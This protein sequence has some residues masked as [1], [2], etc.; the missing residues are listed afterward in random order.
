MAI[1]PINGIL[2]KDELKVME[3]LK[4]STVFDAMEATRKSFEGRLILITTTKNLYHARIEADT[5]L[6]NFKH[7]PHHIS[8]CINNNSSPKQTVTHNFST[9]TAILS[10]TMVTTDNST[11]IISSPN[12]YKRPVIITFNSNKKNL[13]MQHHQHKNA[14]FRQT[15][16]S[17]LI[18]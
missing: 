2:Q 6:A 8:R 13:L 10:Q 18:Q 5:T 12:Q 16:Q 1:V 4:Q 14:N 9:Y 17:S 11:I 15:L 7:Q 3:I